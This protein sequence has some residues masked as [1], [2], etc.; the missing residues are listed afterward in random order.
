[1]SANERVVQVLAVR[2]ARRE[3]LKATSAMVLGLG[4]RLA[5]RPDTA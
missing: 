4:L 2:L 5:T 3:F 1:M